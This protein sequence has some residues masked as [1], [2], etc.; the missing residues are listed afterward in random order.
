MFST[1]KAVTILYNKNVL[2]E[3]IKCLVGGNNVKR[4]G[5]IIDF[6]NI[7]RIQLGI[8]VYYSF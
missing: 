1:K 4:I 3:F 6:K 8:Q 2:D 7:W 5:L